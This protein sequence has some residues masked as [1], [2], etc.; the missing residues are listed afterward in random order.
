MGEDV[1]VSLHPHT[2]IDINEC[3][4]LVLYETYTLHEPARTLPMSIFA[5]QP[6]QG[7]RVLMLTLQVES[8][9]TISFVWYGATWPFRDRFD[10]AGVPGYSF[11]ED[12]Q[13]KYC[14]VLEGV[15]TATDDRERALYVLGEGV[16]RNTAARVLVEGE[17]KP[18]TNAFRFVQQQLRKRTHLHFV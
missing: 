9:D 18:G 7:K 8:D 13:P 3:W 6:V 4:D 14:R 16:L 11:D 10:A 1:V 5:A 12:G 17:L 15:N 2:D